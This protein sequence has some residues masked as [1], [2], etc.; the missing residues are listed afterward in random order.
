MPWKRTCP[1]D[2]RLQFIALVQS[3]EESFSELCRRAGI[4]RKTG[5]KLLRRYE[6]EGAAAFMD[7]P[8][9]ALHI[10]HKLPREL[11]ARIITVRKEHPT[12]GPRKIRAWLREHHFWRVPATSSIGSVLKQYGLVRLRHRPRLPMAA[13]GSSIEPTQEPNDTW[14]IDFKGHFAMQNGKRCHPLTISDHESRYLLICEALSRPTE[15]EARPHLERA[16]YEFGLPKRIR[17]DN[18]VP[19]ATQSL[20]GLSMLS[21]WWIRLG[22]LPERIEPGH[23][24]QNGRHERFHRTLGADVPPQENL[25]EQQL[26]YDRNRTIYNEVRPHEALDMKPPARVYRPSRRRMPALLPELEY[27]PTMKVRKVDKDGRL[28]FAGSTHVFVSKVLANEAVGLEP[29]G[30]DSWR[31]HFGPLPLVLIVARQKSIRLLPLT[32]SQESIDEALAEDCEGD[33]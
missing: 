32:A 27:P 17:S 6:R 13:S 29:A 25:L 23:P 4:S 12:W 14:C 15:L 21:A 7:R 31:L 11:I 20:G 10:R 26:A 9:V 2:E 28:R 33:V 3:S 8:P 22:I 18:G 24:E 1:V 16:F 19:F 30:E 5:Y